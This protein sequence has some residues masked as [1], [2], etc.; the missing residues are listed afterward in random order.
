[1]WS[2]LDDDPCTVEKSMFS[3]FFGCNILKISVKSS[4][5][6]VS[7]RIFVAL[8]SVLK[9]CPFVHYLYSGVLKSPT[10]IILL[11]ISPFVSVI[12]C[13]IY[14]CAPILGAYMLRQVKSSSC[15]DPF[16][17]I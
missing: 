17:I 14:L 7:F 1:M 16:I 15:S 3:A 6:I 9:V 4:R 10:I 13:C 12:I 2:V 11:S 8:F 5:S